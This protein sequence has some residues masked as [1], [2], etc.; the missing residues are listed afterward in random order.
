MCEAPD[1]EVLELIYQD[2][3]SLQA[4]QGLQGMKRWR[5]NPQPWPLKKDKPAHRDEP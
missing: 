5:R 1:E 4:E 3:M 2:R